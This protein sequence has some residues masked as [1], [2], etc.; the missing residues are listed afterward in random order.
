MEALVN[1]KTP[2]MLTLPSLNEYPDSTQLCYFTEEKMD[3]R[4]G[5]H[6]DHG[7][8]LDTQG[9]RKEFLID[10][11]FKKGEITFTYTHIDRVI[12]MGI[13]PEGKALPL[14]ADQKVIGAEYLLERREMGVMNLGGAGT[15]TCDG[16][17]Y[18]V[19]KGEGLYVGKGTKEIVFANATESDPACFYAVSAPAH[20]DYPTV[21][22][23][24]EKAQKVHLG[25]MEESNKRTINQLVHPAVCQ[26]CN[27]VM[28][29]TKL[30][31]GCVWNT[32]PC[33]THE[34]RMEVYFYFDIPE[35]QVVFHLMG[36]PKETRHIVMRNNQAV[37]SPSW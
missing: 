13:V 33:H 24:M 22:I 10:N 7:K 35:G 32:M 18:T 9:L 2:L 11:L 4:N 23:D 16:T 20:M 36:E 12:V 29:Y 37:I 8:I 17:S 14:V 15:V 26:S 21:L 28:G 1:A 5:I 19:K 3:I 31:P 34:R 30:E 6:P 25:S 27:L